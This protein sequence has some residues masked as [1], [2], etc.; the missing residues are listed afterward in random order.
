MTYFLPAVMEVL[1]VLSVDVVV[2]DETKY[3]CDQIEIKFDV[4]KVKV[5]AIL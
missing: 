4:A 1:R 2:V 3:W 5:I